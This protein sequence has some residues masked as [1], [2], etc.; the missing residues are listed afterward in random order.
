MDIVEKLV[1]T[2]DYG[3]LDEE[4][5]E[6]QE[7]IIHIVPNFCVKFQHH[8]SEDTEV[9]PNYGSILLIPYMSPII[10]HLRKVH[11]HGL[12]GRDL[13]VLMRLSEYV[14]EPQLSTELARLVI[15][16]VKAIVN[17]GRNKSSSEDK[18]T[19]YLNILVNLVSNSVNPQEFVG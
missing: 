9:K 8:M 16:A 7:E 14:T 13:N 12:N 17:R 11:S 1:S 10:L 2:A 5:K 19:R 3:E 15:T 18:L 4:N 6:E